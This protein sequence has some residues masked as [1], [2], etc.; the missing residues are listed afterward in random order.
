M[1]TLFSGAVCVC[2]EKWIFSIYFRYHHFMIYEF[3][4]VARRKNTHK[5]VTYIL[6]FHIFERFFNLEIADSISHFFTPPK[7]L[8]M[9]SLLFL[10]FF[11]YIIC[12]V[13]IKCFSQVLITN[14]RCSKL[15]KLRSMFFQFQ[16]LMLSRLHLP[17][18]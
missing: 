14:F 3:V 7:R 2:Y 10:C 11:Y 12:N 6:I 17:L 15:V 9:Y 5:G 18:F 1:S 13:R 8:F 16:S 4:H